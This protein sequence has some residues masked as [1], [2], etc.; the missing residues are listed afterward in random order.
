MYVTSEKDQGG[1]L[2]NLHSRRA[3]FESRIRYQLSWERLVFLNTL[4]Q[5]TEYWRQATTASFQILTSCYR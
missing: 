1:R 5:M 4:R 2:S 3:Q